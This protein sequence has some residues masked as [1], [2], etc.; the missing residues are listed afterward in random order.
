MAEEWDRQHVIREA[1][2]NMQIREPFWA[3]FMVQMQMRWNEEVPTAG[4][5]SAPDGI[6]ITLCLNEKFFMQIGM[7]TNPQY[8]IHPTS[9][10]KHEVNCIASLH[11]NVYGKTL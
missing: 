5:C 11:G 9:V 10:M 4:V 7:R 8:K 6:N 3:D 1:T 2:Y